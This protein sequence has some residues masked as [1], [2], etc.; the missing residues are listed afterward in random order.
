MTCQPR[1][2]TLNNLSKRRT[3]WDSHPWLLNTPA[4]VIDLR[5]GELRPHQREDYF[6]K[7]TAVAPGEKCPQWLAFLKRVTDGDRKLE[8]FLQ[9]MA[10]YALTGS[11]RDEALFFLYGTGANGKAVWPAFF[12]V[13]G[14]GPPD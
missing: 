12:K 6:T 7:I 11:T 10:G 4:G 8:A 1:P 13:C 14:D 3:D 2:D 9:R 5:T